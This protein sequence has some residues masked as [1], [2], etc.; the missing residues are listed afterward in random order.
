MAI[1]KVGIVIFS[2]IRFTFNIGFFL[3]TTNLQAQ[4]KQ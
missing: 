4:F 1:F 3:L 2:E